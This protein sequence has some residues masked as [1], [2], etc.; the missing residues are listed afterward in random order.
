MSFAFLPFRGLD[1]SPTFVQSMSYRFQIGL[2]V[3]KV[4]WPVSRGLTFKPLR[5][6]ILA[7]KG[8]RS[9]PAPTP[10]APPACADS[11][12]QGPVAVAHVSSGSQHVH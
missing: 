3:P 9:Q 8:G 11:Q 2:S 4:L 12:C 1:V 10:K 6:V 7:G 5:Q